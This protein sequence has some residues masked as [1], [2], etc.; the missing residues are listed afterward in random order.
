MSKLTD[1]Q[2][3]KWIK[4]GEWFEGRSDG[5]GGSKLLKGA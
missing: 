5:D 4:A 2:I 3:R 1:I